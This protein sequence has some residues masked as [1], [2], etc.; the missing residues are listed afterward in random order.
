ME[1][2]FR[3]RLL[4]K[5]EKDIKPVLAFSN[6]NGGK[7]MNNINDENRKIMMLMLGNYSE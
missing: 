4:H 7:V 5:S 3:K 1:L 6:T 2:F